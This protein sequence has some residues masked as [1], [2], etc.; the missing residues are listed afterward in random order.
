MKELGLHRIVQTAFALYMCVVGVQFSMFVSWAL[1]KSEIFVPRPSAVEAFLPISALLAAK[2]FVLTGAWDNVHPAGLTLF[3][4]A[5]SSALL[6]RKSFCGYFCP[7]GALSDA[8]FRLGRHLGVIRTLPKYAE[9]L[10]LLPKYVLLAFFLSL[11]FV[12]MSLSD[13][14]DFLFSHYNLVCD[15]KML[16]FFLEPTQAVVLFLLLVILGSIFFPSFWC[17][18]FCPYGALLGLLALCSPFAVQRKESR[19][20]DCG[21]CNR[22][23]P[24]AIRI[25]A[26]KR[27]I[28]PECTA[29]LECVRVCPTSCLNLHLGGGRRS[30]ALSRTS[31]VLLILSVFALFYVWAVMTGHWT[32]EVPKEMVRMLHENIRAVV[33]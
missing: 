16:L 32:S 29:C 28:S 13:I 23:C 3:F 8:L 25:S 22:A 20:T 19:C 27:I 9:Y 31:F 17:R 33:H 1:G 30:V 14:E 26:K 7:L 12:V 4:F 5:L 10:L 2:R 6:L 11:P 24:Q 21:A 18:S 15:T